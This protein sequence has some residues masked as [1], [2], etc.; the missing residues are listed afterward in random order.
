MRNRDRYWACLPAN[1]LGEYATL[2][3][4]RRERDSNWRYA[5][6]TRND[7]AKTRRTRKCDKIN[8]AELCPGA[9]TTG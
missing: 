3:S 4:W 6:A 9:R 2:G 1:S 7:L 5:R 8:E